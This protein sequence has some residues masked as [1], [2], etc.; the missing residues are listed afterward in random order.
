MKEDFRFSVAHASDREQNTPLTEDLD[1]NTGPPGTLGADSDSS[2][3]VHPVHPMHPPRR[4]RL[5][6]QRESVDLD[7]H[8]NEGQSS[9]KKARQA[10]D[11]VVSFSGPS[12]ATSSTGSAPSILRLTPQS[13]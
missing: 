3:L 5:F 2:D 7:R 11:D 9:S 13:D 4:Q 10:S 1:E 6:A 12:E 8:S